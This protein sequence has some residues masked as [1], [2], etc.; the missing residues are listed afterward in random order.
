MFAA[1]EEAGLLESREI[2]IQ[3]DER[4][5]YQVPGFMTISEARLAKLDG[6]NSR[7]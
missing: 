1:F 2:E 5:K 7:S 3:L 6:A 4:T